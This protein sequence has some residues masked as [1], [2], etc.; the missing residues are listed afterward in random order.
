[1]GRSNHFRRSGFEVEMSQ[2]FNDPKLFSAML[3]ALAGQKSNLSQSGGDLFPADPPVPGQSPLSVA[4]LTR[5]LAGLNK[6]APTK[7]ST[8]F[9]APSSSGTTSLAASALVKALAGLSNITS[10]TEHKPLHGLH[11]ATNLDDKLQTDIK[12]IFRERWTTRDGQV[13]P[14]PEDLALDNDAVKLEA[15]VLYADL[16]GSTSLV[17]DYR[18]DFAAEIYKAYL[19]SAARIIKEEGGTITAYDG[20]RIMAVFIGG[21]KNSSAAKAALKINWAVSKLIN[22]SLKAQYGNDTYQMSHVVGID[23]SSILASRIGVRND[24]D[25]VWVG[26]A[27]NYA[28]K[29]SSLNGDHSVYLTGDVF[30]KLHESAKFGGDPRRLMWEQRSWTNM[31]NMRIYGSDWIWT[32]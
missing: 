14:E 9:G 31:N 22:P 2:S 12:K 30:D 8:P 5:A 7:E 23:T 24:N 27:A 19:A 26:R 15:T 13:V 17:D 11:R 4:T 20:D 18:A 28:A 29:L 10:G 3:A 21:F 1:L 32:P 6:P 16:S 25:I